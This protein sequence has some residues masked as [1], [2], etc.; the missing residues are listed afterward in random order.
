M[1]P[2]VLPGPVR[3][4]R[5]PVRL[6]SAA[7]AAWAATAAVSG[8]RRASRPVTV[9][10]SRP[11]SR[12][13]A[14]AGPVIGAGRGDQRGVAWCAAGDPGAGAQHD[15]MA[16]GGRAAGRG[17]A[18]RPP[19]SARDSSTGCGH[20]A[21]A[22]RSSARPCARAAPRCAGRG[23]ARPPPRR[24]RPSRRVLP[25][26]PQPR[27]RR[28]RRPARGWPARPWPA[29]RAGSPPGHARRKPARPPWRPPCRRSGR[30]PRRA[31]AS[32]PAAGAG[33]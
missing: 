8:P 17:S 3:L 27:A 30:A 20:A 25:R 9:S 32:R 21:R 10:G 7:S 5:A 18:A 19:S 4:A 24:A 22:A 31:A 14:D 15:R 23:C 33:R 2:P 6:R 26:L 11:S 13:A 29:A 28:R 16:R 12:M 1:R